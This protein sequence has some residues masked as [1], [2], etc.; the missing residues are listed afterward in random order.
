MGAQLPSV[1]LFFMGLV[2]Y[3]N[4]R[5]IGGEDFFIWWPLVLISLTV[6]IMVLPLPTLYHE[7]RKWFLLS[8]GRLLMPWRPV[9]FQD[10]FLG[11]MMCS[12]TYA[13]GVGLDTR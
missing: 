12:E 6:A 4:F 1:F 7:S 11:D 8:L 13:F 3:L 9:V 10:F 2:M 5:H